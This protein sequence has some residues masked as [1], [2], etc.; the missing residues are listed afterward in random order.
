MV[1]VED[2]R[3]VVLEK[4]LVCHRAG[5]GRRRG[6]R[7]QRQASRRLVQGDRVVASRAAA[8]DERDSR[9]R[10]VHG[11]EVSQV[12]LRREEACRD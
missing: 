11:V 8:G 4:L 7:Q 9:A 10:R 2:V 5:R 12:R 6:R 1:L 3:G